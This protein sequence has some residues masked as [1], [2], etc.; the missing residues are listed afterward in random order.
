MG[1][2]H[3]RAGNSPRPGATDSIR[4]RR[5]QRLGAGFTPEICL[6]GAGIDKMIARGLL[7]GANREAPTPPRP[8]PRGVA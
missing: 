4:R 1:A 5:M 3:T 2:W 7:T 6:S 8:R